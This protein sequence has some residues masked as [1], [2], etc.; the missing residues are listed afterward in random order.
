MRIVLVGLVALWLPGSLQ[1]YQK[2]LSKGVEGNATERIPF[3]SF[4]R[5]LVRSFAQEEVSV[6]R[7]KQ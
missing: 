4:A 7:K 1:S 5:S 3:R 2:E 6:C